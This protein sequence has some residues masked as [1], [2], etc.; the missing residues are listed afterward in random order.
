MSPD[1]IY[2]AFFVIFVATILAAKYDAGA[3]FQ[4][5]RIKFGL[6][7][8]NTGLKILPAKTRKAVCKTIAEIVNELEG[9]QHKK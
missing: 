1:M 7:L 2:E 5:T 9:K 4:E 8:I 6:W 3:C